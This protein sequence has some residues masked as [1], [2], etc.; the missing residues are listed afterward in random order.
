M[1]T[2][3]V[4][5]LLFNPPAHGGSKGSSPEAPVPA[6][7]CCAHRKAGIGNTLNSRCLMAKSRKKKDQEAFDFFDKQAS[8]FGWLVK[9][10]RLI[11][12][13]VGPHVA[14]PRHGYATWLFIRACITAGSLTQLFEGQTSEN[15]AITYLDHPSVAALSRA[16]MENIAVLIYFT[17]DK[18][19]DDEWRC[20][21]DLIDLHDLINRGQF[22][23]QIDPKQKPPP[24]DLSEAQCKLLN[25]NPAF[26][27]IPAARRKRLLAG[28]DMFVQGRHHAMLAFGWG[29][30][31]TRGVYKYVSSHAHSTALAFRRTE[32]NRVY[33]KDSGASQAVA[34]FSLEFASKAFGLGCL[35]MLALFPYV[36]ATFD[37]L[38]IGSLR[39]DYKPTSNP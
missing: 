24:K 26:M 31:L 4:G 33:T 29:H 7:T 22:L 34:G 38:I 19:S 9:Q 14:T 5:R 25:D 30:Q 17:D 6:T 16:L 2:A 8:S 13:R 28:E 10:A 18:L 23:T 1:R 39:A 15:N 3:P 20:R 11:S 36:E 27:A 12:N 32:K 21:R 35:H 37:P